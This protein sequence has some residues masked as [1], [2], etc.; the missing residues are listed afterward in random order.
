[1]AHCDFR[2]ICVAVHKNQKNVAHRSCSNRLQVPEMVRVALASGS[3]VSWG[4][5]ADDLGTVGKTG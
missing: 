2:P 5:Q 4:E 1:M 3:V